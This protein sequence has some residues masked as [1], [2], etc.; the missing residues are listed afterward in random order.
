VLLLALAA[1]APA[2]A[3]LPVTP[4]AFPRVAAVGDIA[5]DPESSF[6]NGGLGDATHC[7]QMQTADSLLAAAPDVVLPLGDIQYEDAQMWKFEQSYDPSWGR[8]KSI[9]RPA[10]GNHEYFAGGGAGYFDYFNG[11]GAVSGPAGDRDKGYYSFDV[12]GWH[13][14]ALNSVCSRVGGCGPGSP[15]DQWLRADLAAHPNPC[16]LAYFHHPLFTSSG[17]GWPSMEPIWQTLYDA[18]V[19]VILNGHA[20]NY[21]RFAPLDATGASDAAFGIRQFVAGTGGKNL[22]GRARAAPASEVFNAG[23]FGSLM[24]TLRPDGYDWNFLRES[25][26]AFSDSGSGA[27]HGAPSGRAPSAETGPASEVGR[28][29]AVANGAID[30]RNQPTSYRFEYG[31]ST[32]YG[33][34]TLETPLQAATGGRQ[35]VSASLEGLR[36]GQTYHYR[37]VATNPLGSVVGPDHTFRAGDAS[38]YAD[39]ITGTFGLLAYWR[40]GEENGEVAFD[41]TSQELGYYTGAHQVGSRGAIAGDADTAVAFDGVNG[42]LRATGPSVGRTATIEGWFRWRDGEVLMRDDSATGGWILARDADGRLGYRVAGKSYATSR[43]IGSV[44]DNAWHHIAMTKTAGLSQL[45]VDG[46]RVHVGFDAGDAPATMP[47]YVMR[48]GPFDGHAAGRADD[49]A[50]YERALPAAEIA[51]HYRAGAARVAPNTV[52]RAPAAATNDATPLIAFGSTKRR[53]K[54]RCAFTTKGARAAFE[55]CRSPR[56]L[57]V[58]ADGTYT[59]SAY[60]IDGLGY[61]DPTPARRSFRV[62]TVTPEVTLAVA[63]RPLGRLVRLGLPT[64]VTCSERCTIAARITVDSRTARRVKLTRRDSIEIGRAVGIASSAAPGAVRIG[65]TSFARKRLKRARALKLTVRVR[66]AD[67]AGNARAFT[68]TLQLRR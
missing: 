1:V 16:T 65:L 12:G 21:E 9:T 44:R 52:L 26:D 28:T 36:P 23:A 61:P 54:T 17:K 63:E 56:R 31:T 50:I 27:C 34:S 7:R 20:H 66:V 62:D 43:S 57:G 53:S 13:L 46:R 3:Q 25:G 59:F 32:A 18:G 8:L 47:W 68:E 38:P 5:C 40:L 30:P 51:A 58:L 2:A 64:T 19:E 49:L 48:N 41:E 37:V 6:F 35:P 22:I 24:L 15:Q 45:F 60:A 14:I 42:T 33:T 67:A 10:I 4:T 39:L 11:A 29:A 55:A